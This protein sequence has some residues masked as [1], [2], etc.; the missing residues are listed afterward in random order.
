LTRDQLV[1]LAASL[2]SGSE[3]PLARAVLDAARESHSSLSAVGAD[4][5]FDSRESQVIF[6]RASEVRALPGRGISGQ[7]GGRILQ[8]GSS[9]LMH[10]LGV[11]AGRLQAM[12]DS[13][14]A[15]GRT[16]SWLAQTDTNGKSQLLGLLAFGDAIKPGAAEAV[17]HLKQM[18]LRVLMISGDSVASARS[19][20]ALLDIADVRA[21][22]LPAD[23]ASVIEAL[24]AEGRVA[25]VGDGI[26]DAPALAAA[27]VG[28]AM[29]G[30][31]DG[32]RSIDAAS[33]ERVDYPAQARTWQ[34]KRPASRCC[35][36]TSRS[37]R[38]LSKSRM[39]LT[40]KSARTSS[41]PSPTTWW[42]FRWRCPAI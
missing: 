42:A 10:E 17:S 31:E 5:T 25:M 11:D 9:R 18:G 12:S 39:P 33:S 40:R 7:V 38:D 30:N 22:V 21:E 28:V 2:Q 19:M 13:H 20:A 16:V 14:Q 35:A 1:S 23:K 6:S 37:Y 36:A 27:D 15:H 24:K 26:N 3:H 29:A 41:G 8:L 34:C 4:A 32:R